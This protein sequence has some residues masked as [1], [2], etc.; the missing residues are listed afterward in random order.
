MAVLLTAL[1]SGMNYD[2]WGLAVSGSKPGL[3]VRIRFVVSSGDWIC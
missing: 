2:V 1:G 3:L